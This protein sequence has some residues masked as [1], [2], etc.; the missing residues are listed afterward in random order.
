MDIHLAGKIYTSSI[1]IKQKLQDIRAT[2]AL[3]QFDM[4]VENIEKAVRQSYSYGGH[5]SIV[6]SISRIIPFFA[7]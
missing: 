6:E 5:C 7:L 2:P 3:L 4:I 1:V